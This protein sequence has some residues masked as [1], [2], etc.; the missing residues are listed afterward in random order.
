MGGPR[1]AGVTNGRLADPLRRAWGAALAIQSAS[2]RS[3]GGDKAL[4]IINMTNRLYPRMRLPGKHQL[5]P[6]AF[7]RGGG[8]FGEVPGLPASFRY[9]VDLGLADHFSAGGDVGRFGEGDEGP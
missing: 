5:L 1:Q 4:S 9:G 3:Y 6:N 8:R 7:V 2:R